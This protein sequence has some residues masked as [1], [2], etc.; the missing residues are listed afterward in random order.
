MYFRIYQAI[1]KDETARAC[2]ASTPATLFRPDHRRRVPPGQRQG[3]S[4]WREILE[5]FE[6]AF[7]IGMTA[8]AQAGRQ[9]D[10]YR[11]F[12]NP[13]Y[14]YS[15]RQGIDDGF[16]PRTGPPRGHHVGTPR[17][18]AF[19]GDIDRY[20][21][22]IPRRGVPHQRIRA[23]HRPEGQNR[24]RRQI[25]LTEYMKR[26]DRTPRPSSS[27]DQEHADEMRRALTNLNSDLV[28][29]NPDYVC[30]V[31]SDEGDIGRDKRRNVRRGSVAPYVMCQR[32]HKPEG[33]C[34]P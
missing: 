20:G 10:T 15:L 2:T 3:R 9:I 1:A 25:H 7:Q 27:G 29:Q 34:G 30:R 5:Y 21:R 31:T 18:A 32:D 28:R 12:G 6:P 8:T 14:T 19:A 22:E 16:L 13:I 17:L 33:Q 26:T 24:G 4:N 11:Y 23:D